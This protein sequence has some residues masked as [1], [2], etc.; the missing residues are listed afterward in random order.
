MNAI[1]RLRR[2]TR[3]LSVAAAA[4]EIRSGRQ[5]A[6]SVIGAIELQQGAQRGAEIA[7]GRLEGRA[8]VLERDLYVRLALTLNICVLRS[9]RALEVL[10]FRLDLLDLRV[11]DF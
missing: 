6:L 3:I 11:A 8:A 9:L 5:I 4:A 10:N 2:R 1:L 7:I